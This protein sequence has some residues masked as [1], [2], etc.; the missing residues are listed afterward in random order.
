MRALACGL[1]VLLLAGCGARRA[2]PPPGSPPSLKAPPNEALSLE[3]FASGVQIY[4]C[5]TR[6]WVLKAPEA[7]LADRD[8]RKIG[9]HY[10]GP[11]WEA[12][13]GSSVVG[14]P[15]ARENAR[16]ADDIPW[17][18]LSAKSASGTMLKAGFPSTRR[19]ATTCS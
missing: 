15:R 8:G 12:N 3:A 16:S 4:E 14:E 1:I 13:D 6:Q 7:E 19:S 18:L 17:L 10:A 9:R 5:R 2:L 11:T